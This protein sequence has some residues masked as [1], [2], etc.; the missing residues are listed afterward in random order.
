ME[1]KI[2][3]KTEK[4]QNII[5][6]INVRKNEISQLDQEG[7]MIQGELRL[8]NELKLEKSKSKKK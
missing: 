4:L 7:L 5:K 8:L 3:Q 2:K 1:E 6:Q